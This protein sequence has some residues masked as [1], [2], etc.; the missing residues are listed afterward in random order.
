MGEWE[1]AVRS[2]TSDKGEWS[3]ATA[4]DTGPAKEKLA[5]PEPANATASESSKA[6]RKA[7]ASQPSKPAGE[8]TATPVQTSKSP[9]S[10][11][12]YYLVLNT[13]RVEAEIANSLYN[14]SSETQLGTYILPRDSRRFMKVFKA[15]AISFL[16]TS[17]QRTPDRY[18]NL[19]RKQYRLSLSDRYLKTCG[20]MM[21][22]LQLLWK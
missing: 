21:L 16:Q 15:N 13:R 11:D 22:R 12:G 7:Q 8:H 14:L 19:F 17:H 20:R 18:L 2:E 10:G 4:E 3:T 9:K 1:I 5:F 6:K